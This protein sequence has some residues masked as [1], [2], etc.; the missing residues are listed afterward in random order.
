[1]FCNLD[2]LKQPLLGSAL[3]TNGSISMRQSFLLSLNMRDLL[4]SPATPNGFAVAV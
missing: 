2:Y 1:M 3:T 4:C